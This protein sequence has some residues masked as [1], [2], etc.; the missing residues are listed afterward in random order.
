MALQVE[1][2][3]VAATI[4]VGDGGVGLDPRAERRLIEAVL[5]AVEDRLARERRQADA[6]D[7]PDDGR[8]GVAR[9]G[10]V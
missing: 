2:D 10:G 8:G 4:R 5:A 3:E 6:T 9:G 1:I 7:I